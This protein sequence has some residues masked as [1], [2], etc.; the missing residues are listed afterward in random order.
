MNIINNSHSCVLC[1]GFFDEQLM[2]NF[3]SDEVPD[4]PYFVE[5]RNYTIG[6]AQDLRLIF[7][8]S[9]R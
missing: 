3:C 7:D 5:T 1:S 2:N 6:A 4:V 8:F 9:D